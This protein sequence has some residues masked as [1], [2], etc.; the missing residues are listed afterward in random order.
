MSEPYREWI[1]G[2]IDSLRS[3]KA[4]PDLERIC[5]MVKRRHGSDWDRTRTELEKLIEEQTVLKVNYKGSVSYR[6][7]AKVLRGRRKPEHSK[8]AVKEPSPPDWSTGDSAL[9]LADEDQMEDMEDEMSTTAGMD[10][11]MDEEGDESSLDAMCAQSTT[12]SGISM[13]PITSSSIS[14]PAPSP[15]TS[16]KSSPTH[17][18]L[19]QDGDSA[20]ILPDH[21]AQ[22]QDTGSPELE[23]QPLDI[24]LY[25]QPAQQSAPQEEEV[26][27]AEESALT[28]DPPPSD[29]GATP[30]DAVTSDRA[31]H[32]VSVNVED[33]EKCNKELNSMTEV[34]NGG[35]NDGT[36]VLKEDIGQDP[37]HWTVADVAKYITSVGFPEQAAA[38]KT[39]EIDGKS[40]MLMQRS[41][42]LTGLSI[43]LGPAL[44]IY[45]NHVKVLQ[46]SHFQ[47]DNRL[48]S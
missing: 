17:D 26:P 48:F 3:R 29:C 19:R 9:G 43:R 1:L 12:D 8:C 38:F 31:P 36:E 11:S 15:T 2:S 39:Q 10:S 40:L 46:R 24:C 18:A 4:R 35:I 13:S 21:P 14:L 6:N 44:K 33:G 25:A 41:D 28:S 47:D 16:P 34:H 7:A 45:E 37:S 5:R 32:A 22:Q 23:Q 30:N 20:Y 42:V 27:R